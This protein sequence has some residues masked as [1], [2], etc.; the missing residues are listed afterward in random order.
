MFRPMTAVF[1]FEQVPTETDGDVDISVVMPCLNEESSVEECVRAAWAG[2]ARTGLVGEVV[3]ADNGSTDRSVERAVAA[4]ARV[5]DQ[6]RKGYGNAYLKGFSAS[7]GRIIVMGDSDLSYDFTELHK[8]VEPLVAGEADYCLGSRFG[9]E[10]LPGAMT[11]SHR[12]IGNP[13]LTG[14]LNRFFGL[15]S[16]DA[17]SGM[18]AFTREAVERM[19]LRCEGMEFASELVIK[20]AAAGLRV[21]ERPIRYHP[22]IGETKLRTFRDG[23]RHLRF[24]LLLA[25][26]WLFVFP[27]LFLLALGLFGQIV[28]L[29]GEVRVGAHQLDVHFSALLALFSVLGF[30]S[31]TFGLFAHGYAD[32]LGM[33]GRGRLARWVEEDFTLERGLFVGVLF[34]TTGLLVDGWV[35]LDWLRSGLGP[36]NAMRQALIAMTFMALGADLAFA[37]FFLGLLKVRVRTEP[38][39]VAAV[40]AAP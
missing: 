28:L 25:P 21:A 39:A 26:N 17:H 23:W 27:G 10:I 32:L 22:R 34:F 19:G 30:Q 11:F 15:R 18:R 36:L 14:I 5:V 3:V 38:A 1:D 40:P 31:I 4:G 6:P 35:L 2:I 13:V 12:Y 16:S 8:L 9:G 29:G 7:R 33:P 20:A 37:S 24:M